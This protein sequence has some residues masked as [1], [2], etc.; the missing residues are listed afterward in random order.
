MLTF[1]AEALEGQAN[2]LFGESADEADLSRPSES[3]P[4]LGHGMSAGNAGCTRG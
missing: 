2:D 3:G 4:S 1:C